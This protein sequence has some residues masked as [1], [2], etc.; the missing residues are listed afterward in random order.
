M[1][2]CLLLVLISLQKPQRDTLPPIRAVCARSGLG[3]IC[4]SYSRGVFANCAELKN[5]RQTTQHTAPK[6]GG[7]ERTGRA[8]SGGVSP[9]TPVRRL[10]TTPTRTASLLDFKGAAFGND[11]AA[12]PSSLA[13]HRRPKLS[14]LSPER[15]QELA[16]E[17]EFLHQRIREIKEEKALVRRRAEPMASYLLRELLLDMIKPNFDL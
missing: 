7:G 1:G 14:E 6:P 13:M 12:R 10:S 4:G 5:A 17:E 3:R 8:A 9:A 15:Q 11:K 16:E 2:K